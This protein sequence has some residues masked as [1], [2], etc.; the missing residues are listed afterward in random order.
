M[1]GYSISIRDPRSE[2]SFDLQSIAKGDYP[3]FKSSET[4]FGRK[5]FQFKWTSGSKYFVVGF[6]ST[7]YIVYSDVGSSYTRVHIHKHN[8]TDSLYDLDSS[9]I[10]NRNYLYCID[11]REYKFLIVNESQIW[12][13][14]Y[15]KN[16]QKMNL[17]V[18]EHS[19]CHDSFVVK[20]KGPFDVELPSSFFTVSDY[21]HFEF[22]TC[23]YK[24]KLPAI[25]SLIL[26]FI[27]SYS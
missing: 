14:S 15:P 3:T 18:Q 16:A 4:I 13:F 6:N 25:L 19:N 23:S 10:A 22:A 5:C 20:M 27:V 1:T 26:I 9:L 2:I 7:D 21:R 12:S 8:A 17:Y 24:R 11:T